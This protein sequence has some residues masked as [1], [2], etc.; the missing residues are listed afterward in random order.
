MNI[1]V[2]VGKTTSKTVVVVVISAV[3]TSTAWIAIICGCLFLRKGKT[4]GGDLVNNY[5]HDDEQPKGREF[6]NPFCIDLDSS[7]K[8]YFI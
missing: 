8:N 2:S 1:L 3:I 4:R 7:F 5:R 6:L